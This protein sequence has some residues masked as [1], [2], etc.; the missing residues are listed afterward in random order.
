M[1]LSIVVP[2]FNTRRFLRKCL[3]SIVLQDAPQDLFEVVVVDDGSTDDSSTI[4]RE[5]TERYVNVTGLWQ[6]NS[7]LGAARN[8]GERAARGRYV[9]FVDAD[10]FLQNGALPSLLE[11]LQE[12][13]PDVMVLDLT[14]A[15]ETGCFAD[16]ITTGFS[17]D[18]GKTLTGGQF[19]E[20]HFRTTY[21][22]LYVFSRSL[23]VAN[24]IR[25]EP[26]IN[27]QDAE[28]LPRALA[29]ARHVYLSGISA[30]VYVKRQDSYINSTDTDTRR[31][32][33]LSVV[34]VHQRLGAFMKTVA[35]DAALSR[36]LRSKINAIEEILMLSLIYDRLSKSQ[37]DERRRV[38]SEKGIYPF[39]FT[40]GTDG[41]PR[42]KHLLLKQAVNLF[43]VRFPAGFAA[44]RAA[45]HRSKYLRGA[46]S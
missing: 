38:L 27:M 7:G 24:G 2:A 41:L 10:D 26:R 42:I 20:R 18:A 14:C 44:V 8:A 32:Y 3:E 11:A 33:F 19:F 31:R 43:P 17:E 21:A 16:W 29:K 30:Y 22:V 37:R 25:F 6:E 4:I 35:D 39:Y 5:F 45:Y 9:W 40:V 12:H 15:D 36:G 34:E 23:L 1:L 28:M 13:Q 46:R